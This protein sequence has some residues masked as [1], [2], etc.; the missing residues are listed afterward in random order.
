M[1][2]RPIEQKDVSACADI[3][4]R[5]YAE[6]PQNELL[7]RE[8]AEEYIKG[9]FDRSGTDSFVALGKSGQVVGF[10]FLQLSAWVGGKQAILEEIVVSPDVQRTGVGSELLNHVEAHLRSQYVTSVL[11]WVKKD[12]R[13]LD[14]YK[15]HG[16]GVDEGFVVMGKEIKK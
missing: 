5:A 10:I 4:M 14:F 15:K 9:K 7:D 11:L 8:T 13:L 12:E 2:I 6:P 1:N 16:Y 3:L